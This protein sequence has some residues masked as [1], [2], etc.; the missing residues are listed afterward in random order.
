[1]SRLGSLLLDL[2]ETSSFDLSLRLTL[3]DFL[4]RPIGDWTVRPF[5]LLLAG[6][7]LLSSRL[8]RHPATW[9]FFTALTG[10]R[11]IADWPMSDNHA[12]L[13]CYWCLAVFLALALNDAGS[14]QRNARLLVGLAFL[15]AVTWKVVLAPDF[16]DG[17]F[18]RVSLQLDG[19]FAP[20]AQLVGDLSDG[21]L[22]ESRSFL[23]PLP[24]GPEFAEPPRLHESSALRDLGRVA[25]WWTIFV[26]I[27]VAVA[28]LAPDRFSAAWWR[29]MPL[30]GFCATTY[31]LAP[32]AGF[33]WLLLV[34]GIVQCDPTQGRTRAAYLAV[35]FL[36]LFYREVPWAEL[37]VRR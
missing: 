34:M 5:V 23:S 9:L 8:L 2:R 18:F 32:V 22:S 27:A 26:E 25:T 13:L 16:M 19:R 36:I 10:W 24:D 30:L 7:G 3:L 31:A 11:V 12:Y 33:G 35:F 14:L 15:F 4:L 17:R 21:E 29:H 1:M 6:L 20:I 28:F 37:L